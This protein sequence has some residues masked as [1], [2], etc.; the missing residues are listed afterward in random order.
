L[1]KYPEKLTAHSSTSNSVSIAAPSGNATRSF[2]RVSQFV[3]LVPKF[4]G[5]VLLEPVQTAPAVTLAGLNADADD[6]DAEADD[7]ESKAQDLRDNDLDS[8]ADELGRAA[9]G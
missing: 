9:A 5:L 6:L 2:G 7:L 8:H 3:G 4:L 1:R